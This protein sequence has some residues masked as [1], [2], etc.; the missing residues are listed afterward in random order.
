TSLI[1]AFYYLRVIKVMWMS[2][3]ESQAVL[4]IPLKAVV[5]VTAVATLV[6]GLLP[7]PLMDVASRALLSLFRA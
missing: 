5:G 7:A 1:S 6:L 3:G 4:P 2:G